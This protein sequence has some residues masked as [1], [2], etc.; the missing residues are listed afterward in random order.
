M[1]DSLAAYNSH[2]FIRTC[3]HLLA[4][5]VAWSGGEFTSVTTTVPGTIAKAIQEQRLFDMTKSLLLLGR[6]YV[7]V[8][9]T[10]GDGQVL[11]FPDAPGVSDPTIVEIKRNES[12]FEASGQPI[13]QDVLPSIELYEKA[14][15]LARVS[16]AGLVLLGYSLPAIHSAL[17][18]SP[19]MI[20]Q[21]KIS[22]TPPEVLM[23][24]AIHF[25]SE[26]ELLRHS[27]RFGLD[28][29]GEVLG[30]A[31]GISDLEWDWNNQW[32]PD[33]I[34]KYGHVFQVFQSQGLVLEPVRAS[35]LGGLQLAATS[36]LISHATLVECQASYS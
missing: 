8:A 27:L 9:V 13:L 24:G 1:T 14:L 4:A 5:G 7:K 33:G 32:L 6:A 26:V 31:V 11:Q 20:D 19:V 34:C 16:P 17:A 36:G 10:E 15:D 21:G 25:I 2:D 35:E 23:M 28:R 22:K 12:E 30:D 18:I 3:I 29:V